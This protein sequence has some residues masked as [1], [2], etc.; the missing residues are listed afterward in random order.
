MKVKQQ[1]QRQQQQQQQQKIDDD[2][3][4]LALDGPHADKVVQLPERHQP[5]FP[6]A[7]QVPAHARARRGGGGS[8]QWRTAEMFGY[9]PK[10]PDIYTRQEKQA[11]G[12]GPR[13]AVMFGYV[14]KRSR[15]VHGARQ[16][17]NRRG[18]YMPAVPCG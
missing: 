12:G 6:A 4:S 15:F 13:I 2:R 10:G 8:E 11:T 17:G 16:A 7:R 18:I 5:V 14:L 9:V 3:N 1:Q